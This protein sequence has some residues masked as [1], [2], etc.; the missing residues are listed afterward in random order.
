EFANPAYATLRGATVVQLQGSDVLAAYAPAARPRVLP[1]LEAADRPGHVTYEAEFTRSDGS[2]I[3]VQLDITSVRSPTGEVLYRIG[4]AQDIRERK[5]AEAME[6]ALQTQ[7]QRL[8]QILDEMPIAMALI[9]R[10]S[11]RYE[12]VN[13][14][15]C[16]MLDYTAEEMIGRKS[17]DFVD[18]DD[19]IS[20]VGAANS[21]L[22]RD[23]ADIRLIA[24]SGRIVHVRTR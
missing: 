21:L 22:D 14:T 12:W 15:A 20:P 24:K 3:P 13:S 18:D 11:D 6:A 9:A 2:T 1:L 17:Q 23:P 7:D 8:R 16:R 19:D 5:R 10:D 4:S